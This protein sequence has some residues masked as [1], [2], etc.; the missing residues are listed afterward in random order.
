MKSTSDEISREGPGRH[1]R[2]V[3]SGVVAVAAGLVGAVVALLIGLLTFGVQ[4]TI[5]P[6][7]VPLA[8]GPSDAAD[9][10]AM[11][12][13]L[14][15]VAAQGGDAVTWRTVESRAQAE[16][17]LDA[18]EVYGAVLIGRGATGPSA[19]VLLSAALNPSAAQV[20]QPVLTQVGGTVVAAARAQAARSPQAAAGSA[21]AAPVADVQ[22][23]T[24]H[25]TSAAGRTLPLAASAL[26]WL[27]TLIASILA[28]VLVPRLRG[29]RS[30][31]RVALVCA[32][33]TGALLGVAVVVGLARLWDAGLPLGRE[34]VG[35]LALVGV[36]FALLQSGILRWLG[37]RGLAV[38]VPLYLMAPAV[39][40]L[41]P[42]VIDPV[43]RE[44]LWSWTPFRFS[45]EGLRS[46][47]FLGSN[48]PDVQM[49]L[50]IFGGMALAGLAL[51]VAPGP[52]PEAVSARL[53]TARPPG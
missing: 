36:A 10:Q 15:Q 25:P 9:A 38:L 28:I 17:L 3:P 51:T 20:A 33:V 23:V 24:L 40:G 12:P 35:F 13:M 53:R 27:A 31:G 41:V 16:Q 48:A 7:H 47:M 32:A 30:L 39:A 26:L 34:A 46:L 50:W 2:G 22:V 42:E 49:A 44:A 6:D 4:A 52:R 8:I 21:P 43:Y 1:G 19:T 29:G 11:A 14:E 18:K 37:L 45:T 5:R